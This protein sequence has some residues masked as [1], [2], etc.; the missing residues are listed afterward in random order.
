MTDGPDFAVESG[1]ER[2]LADYLSAQRPV[3]DAGFRGS[4]ARRMAADDRGYGPRP[5]RLRLMVLG[6]VAA[7]YALIGVG[8][9]TAIGIL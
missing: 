1:D 2:E 7:G 9:L 6:Y 4:L 5:E 3:P 8:V